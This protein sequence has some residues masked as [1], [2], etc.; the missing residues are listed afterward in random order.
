M[1][2]IGKDFLYHLLQTVSQPPMHVATQPLFAT[3]AFELMFV[4]KYTVQSQ[5]DHCLASG[6]GSNFVLGGP[7]RVWSLIWL[8]GEQDCSRLLYGHFLRSCLFYRGI[9][10]LKI[11]RLDVIEHMDI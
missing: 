9:S 6:V 1:A 4:V 2:N 8:G 10:C 5:L 11:T 7:S 3:V